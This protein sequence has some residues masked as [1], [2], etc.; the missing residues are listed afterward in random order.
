MLLTKLNSTAGGGGLADTFLERAQVLLEHAIGELPGDGLRF[1][2]VSCLS[3]IMLAFNWASNAESAP[4]TP[5][6]GSDSTI[7]GS[8]TVCTAAG[9][10]VMTSGVLAIC[11]RTRLGVMNSRAPK[12]RMTLPFSKAI[13]HGIF[14]LQIPN[15]V[16]IGMADSERRGR[17]IDL[18]QTAGVDIRILDVGG[19]SHIV[20]QIAV[21]EEVERLLW[22]TAGG[23]HA[24]GEQ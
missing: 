12:E 14:E 15:V 17:I 9:C 4:S 16:A 21:L 10:V 23:Q 13:L 7:A 6:I 2:G 22:R 19:H 11:V 20:R 8:Y 18:R 24:Q 3:Q 5:K 1:C